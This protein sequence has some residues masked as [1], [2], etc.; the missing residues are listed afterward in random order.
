MQV[1]EISKENKIKIGIAA[2]VMKEG[3]LLLGKRKS[4]HAEGEYAAPGGHMEYMES[5]EDCARREIREETGLEVGEVKFLRLCNL[6]EYA[7]QHYMNIALVCE[8]KSGEPKNMEPDKCEGWEWYSLDNLPTPLHK[9]YPSI[10][11][12]LK[13]GRSYFDL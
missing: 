9:A 4:V 3:K 1:M 13:T 10:L 12:A 7:P 5:I 2:L 8:W 11:E 6:R